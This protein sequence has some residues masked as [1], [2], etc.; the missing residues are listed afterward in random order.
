MKVQHLKYKKK[1]KNNKKEKRKQ[2][3]KKINLRKKRIINLKQKI[4]TTI[5]PKSLNKKYKN[6]KK[7]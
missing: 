5:L 7:K 4:P 2:I 3:N 1:K 6:Q